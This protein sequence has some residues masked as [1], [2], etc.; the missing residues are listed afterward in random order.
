MK[1]ILAATILF[2]LSSG[3]FAAD[4]SI[5]AGG[6]VGLLTWQDIKGTFSGMPAEVVE[7]GIPIDIKVFA[8]I[9]IIQFS[10]GYMFVTGN[11]QTATLLGSTATAAMNGFASYLTFAAYGKYP[12][13]F[14]PISVFPLVGL[15]FRYN[16]TWSV[17]ALTKDS[18]TS[19]EQVSLN[20]LWLQGGAGMDV[21]FGRLYLRSE[22]L[23]G[24]KPV[25]GTFDSDLMQALGWTSTSTSYFTVSVG[26]LAGFKL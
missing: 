24:F 2:A 7:R 5:G 10:V 9:T 22:V 6:S 3:A 17:G 8:D 26:L 11:S 15:E 14:G 1:K 4:F 13:T 12:F 25:L 21:S 18:L 20:E 23:A 16:L 19:A